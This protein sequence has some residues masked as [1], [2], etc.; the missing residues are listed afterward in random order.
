VA[1]VAT[2]D[3]FTIGT[4]DPGEPPVLDVN[5]DG[6]GTAAYMRSVCA[7]ATAVGDT[8]LVEDPVCGVDSF[9]SGVDVIRNQRI[10]DF[11]ADAIPPPQ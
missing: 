2:G 6:S 4:P 10:A 3:G 8:C 9:R 7:A 5:G 1:G 11:L